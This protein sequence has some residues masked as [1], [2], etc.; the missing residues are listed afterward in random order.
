MPTRRRKVHLTQPQRTELETF[1][2]HGKKSARE[3]NRARVLLLAEEGKSD[4]EIARLLGLSRGT[5]YNVRR[6]YQA[7]ARRPLGE[8]LH[9][10]PRSGRPIQL[11]SQVEAKATLIACSDPPV[12]RG[13]WTLHLIADKLVRRGVTDSISPES[14]RTLLKK[15]NLSRGEVS[16]GALGRLRATTSGIGK[17]C[18]PNTNCPMT[19]GIPCSVLMND[20]VSSLK[21]SEASCP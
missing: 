8:V 2:A 20:L 14:V 11:D 10:A 5:V 17:T 21:T 19:R 12:G 3:I 13:R 4:S 16:S 15:T 6:K 18:W 7:Q 9:D 1:V